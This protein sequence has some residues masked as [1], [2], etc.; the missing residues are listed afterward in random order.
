MEEERLIAGGLQ[1]ADI[2]LETS[3][4]PRSLR[5]YFGQQ[6]DLFRTCFFYLWLRES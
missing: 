5:E 2:E 4:R 6:K 1:N 3:L